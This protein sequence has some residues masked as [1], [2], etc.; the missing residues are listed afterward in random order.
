MQYK[1]TCK[2]IEDKRLRK[3]IYKLNKYMLKQNEKVAYLYKNLS[4]NDTI[5]FNPEICFYKNII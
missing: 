1:I 3:K 4:T 2:S 5:S